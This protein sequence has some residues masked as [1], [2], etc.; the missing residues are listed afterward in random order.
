MAIEALKHAKLPEADLAICLDASAIEAYRAAERDAAAKTAGSLRSKKPTVDD[1]LRDA[2]DRATLRLKLRGLPRRHWTDLVKDHPPRKDNRED[3]QVGYNESTFYVAMV[4]ACIV[5]PVVTDE[6]WD[7]ID[8]VLTE[9]E[10]IRLVTTVQG[11]NLRNSQ[12]PF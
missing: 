8:A 3:R 5:D 6:D 11:L 2:V 4:R 12:L 7:E 9:G 10:W 1:E